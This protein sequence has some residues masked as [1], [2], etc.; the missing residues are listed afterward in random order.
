[1]T[2]TLGR[3]IALALSVVNIAGAGFAIASS[4]PWHAGAHISL[5]LVFA[6]AA[7][8]LKAGAAGNDVAGL[9]QQLDDQAAAIEDA[10]A[11]LALQS[12]QLAELHERVD[13]AERMLAQARDRT[14]LGPS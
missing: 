11:K 4:E 7:T 1:M 14:K 13:F 2:Q 12:T 9:R 8:R 10:Q 6:F 5:A 3:R